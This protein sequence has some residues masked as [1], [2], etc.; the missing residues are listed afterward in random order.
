[1]ASKALRFEHVIDDVA[2]DEARLR[3]EHS[4]T[5]DLGLRDVDADDVDARRDHEL[6]GRHARTAADVENARAGTERRGQLPDPQR[7]AR[8]RLGAAGRGLAVVGPV[9]AGDRVVTAP[10]Q[11]ALCNTGVGI[12][13][14]IGIM[15]QARGWKRL[16]SAVSTYAY[17][18]Q[19][20]EVRAA[21]AADTVPIVRER[22]QPFPVPAVALPG[23]G[24]RLSAWRRQR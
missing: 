17:W 24:A 11:I 7:V 9:R 15:V 4:R 23:T 5:V 3:H 13:G 14:H 8:R 20:L 22:S 19:P 6:V 1:M 2:A 10:Y 12:G 16:I 18:P 21:H